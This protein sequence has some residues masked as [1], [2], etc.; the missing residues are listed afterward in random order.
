MGN[1]VKKT[2]GVLKCCGVLKRGG[3]F[4]EGGFERLGLRD[5]NALSQYCQLEGGGKGNQKGGDSERGNRFL[6]KSR[7]AERRTTEWE[8]HQ[9]RGRGDN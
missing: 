4:G 2:W 5:G 3:S 8:T 1:D 7:G 6:G 9:F